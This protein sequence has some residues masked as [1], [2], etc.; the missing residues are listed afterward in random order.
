MR[1]AQGM[2]IKAIATTAN[3]APTACIGV[4]RS[5][6]KRRAQRTVNAG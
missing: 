4:I 5:W 3:A 1:E 6:V 2:A